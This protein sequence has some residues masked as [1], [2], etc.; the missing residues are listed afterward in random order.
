MVRVAR[1][2]KKKAGSGKLPAGAG[3]EIA[4]DVGLG[5]AQTHDAVARLPLTT[6]LEHIEALEALQDVA[7]DD[8]AGG[9]LE[10]F[11]LRHDVKGR[12]ATC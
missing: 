3:N 4:S 2:G 7:F 8:E 6:L 9:A 5:L 10:T 12:V 11:V 1:L